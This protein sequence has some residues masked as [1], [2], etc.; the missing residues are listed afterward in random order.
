M[1]WNRV[2]SVTSDVLAVVSGIL[3]AA[4]FFLVLSAPFM[5]GL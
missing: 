4:P 1:S 5:T 3:I 2:A